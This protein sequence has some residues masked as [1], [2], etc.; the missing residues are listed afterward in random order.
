[1]GRV[2]DLQCLTYRTQRKEKTAL[3][4]NEEQRQTSPFFVSPTKDYVP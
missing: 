1:M 4:E 2:R 3:E